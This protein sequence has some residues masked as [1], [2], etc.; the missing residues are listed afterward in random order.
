MWGWLIGGYAVFVA[1]LVGYAAH[2]ALSSGEAEHRA[3]AYEVLKLIWGTATG[4][5]GL[6]AIVVR[7]H[8]IG[9]L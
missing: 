1:V 3:D 9:V 7:L 5:G 8:Q 4:A 6:A 2:V